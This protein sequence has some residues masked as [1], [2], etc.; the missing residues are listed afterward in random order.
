MYLW[1]SRLLCPN[2][3][4]NRTIALSKVDFMRY[5]AEDRCPECEVANATEERPTGY[6]TNEETIVIVQQMIRPPSEPA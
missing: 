3:L 4:T 6:E 2:E 1:G 5:P